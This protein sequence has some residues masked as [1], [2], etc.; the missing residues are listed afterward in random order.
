[1]ESTTGGDANDEFARW[2]AETARAE[3]AAAPAQPPVAAPVNPPV[4]PPTA[5]PAEAPSAVV[6]PAAAPPP[7]AASPIPPGPPPA[8]EFFG[9]DQLAAPPTRPFESQL[10]GPQVARSSFQSPGEAPVGRQPSPVAPAAAPASDTPSWAPGYTGA[11]GEP[12]QQPAAPPSNGY[13]AGYGAPP[14]PAPAAFFPDAAPAASPPPPSFDP[15]PAQAPIAPSFDAPLAAQSAAPV[16]P[17]SFESTAPAAPPTFD[18]PPTFAS[19]PVPAA[20]EAPVGPAAFPPLVVDTT[21]P[22]A[23]A[24]SADPFGS[25][26]ATG[27]PA[28]DMAA[29]LAASP[30]PFSEP[31]PSISPSSSPSTGELLAD[32]DP[33]KELFGL[34]T[35]EQ[36]AIVLDPQPFDAPPPV[37][38]AA[39]VQVPPVASQLPTYTPEST[40]PPAGA[41]TPEPAFAAAPTPSL[42][43][44]LTAASSAAGSSYALTAPSA[45]PDDDDP[46]AGTQFFGGGV[47]EWEEPPDLDRTTLGERVALVLAFLIPP[48]G[49]IASIVAA[50]QSSRER[51]WVLRFVR[52]SV[53]IAVIMT[54]VAGFG[55]AYFYKVVDDG[56]KHDAIAAASTQFCSTVADNPD[57]ISPPSFG[58]PAPGASIPDTITAIQAYVDR[59]D[60]LAAVS[61]SGIRTDVTRVADSARGIL[62]TVTDTRLVNY[63]D[64]IAVMSSVAESTN[65]VGW[66]EEYCG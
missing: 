22:P 14:A 49:L 66:A 31:P 53:V 16:A 12:P 36:P 32:E 13:N 59:W 15:P 54:V 18:V 43:P 17:P 26:F 45:T 20:S 6:P 51:G 52:T 28:D 19:E 33:L 11:S 60:A 4:A 27:S 29:R 37:E 58:F 21:V 46:N 55:A 64:N 39:P 5:T 35:E 10:G 38:P 47:G 24:S 1:M 7:P 62:T 50:V 56:R 48:V 57:M 63:D 44:A 9:A 40:F 2:L 30:P 61:P 8:P 65:V 25:L 23:A 42:E 41:Y 3:Q 34:E